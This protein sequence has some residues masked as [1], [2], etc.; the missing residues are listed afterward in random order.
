MI[1]ILKLTK[2][3]NQQCV[4]KGVSLDFPDESITAILGPSGS[5]KSTLLRLISG[6]DLP[7]SGEIVMDGKC[8]SNSKSGTPP[9]TRQLGMMFQRSALWPHMTVLGNISFVVQKDSIHN[10]HHWIA[11]LISQ[12]EIEHIAAR[13]PANL[14][15]GEARRVALARALANQSRYLLLDE[16]LTSLDSRS[17][18]RLINVIRDYVTSFKATMIYVTHNIAEISDIAH[19]I[20]AIEQGVVTEHDLDNYSG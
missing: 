3:F 14:S 16:P 15:G 4:V 1:K 2:C 5:G 17:C 11:Y 9:H 19:K 7:D 12:L 6:L 18:T 10:H 20:F 13:Y 8:V